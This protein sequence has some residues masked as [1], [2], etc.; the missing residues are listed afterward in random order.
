MNMKA[1]KNSTLVVAVIAVV[2][3]VTEA[4]RHKSQEADT[5]PM[6]VEVA[7]PVVDSVVLRKTYP[8]YLA[9]NKE[10][11]LV[12]RVDG[13]LRDQL[14]KSGDFV[15]EGQ[16]L[17]QIEND[18]YL[19]AV[20]QAQ[21]TLATA[22]ATYDYAS[23]EYEA[24]KTAYLSDAVS[25]MEVVQAKSNLDQSIASINTAKAALE[26]AQTDLNYCAVR[27]PYSGHISSAQYDVGAYLGGSINPVTLAYLY[28][29][30]VL[31]ALFDITD[32]G[33]FEMIKQRADSMRL[34]Y[35][36]IPITF[37]EPLLH[38]YTADLSYVAPQ[39]DKSTGT[40]QLKAKIK[41]THGELKGG[42]YA[43]IA[44]PYA[45]VPQAL[46]IK[47]A[48]IS[49][50]QLGKY[51][52]TVDEQNKVVYTPIEIGDLVNDTLRIV[53]KG[54]NDK[55]RYVTKAVLKVRDGMTVEPK[56]TN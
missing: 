31:S 48:S 51:V 35:S 52:Y 11:A 24:M 53:T 19:D 39:I 32:V 25:Q 10:V 6:T 29:D 37:S 26:T 1:L 34:D 50:N 43:M 20:E 54:L 18:K 30:T 55:S 22:M 44:L 7:L 21:A 3:C 36:N 46:L 41:N 16:L 33:Y 28:D 45:V 15:T 23:K 8:G 42:M 17:F 40:L 56:V 49:S 5:E 38:D 27:A 13:Y 12:S 14:Y 9:S 47:D 4:C 2:G